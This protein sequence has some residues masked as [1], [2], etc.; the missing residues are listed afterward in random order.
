MARRLSESKKPYTVQVRG[1]TPIKKVREYLKA[2][3][4]YQSE[5]PLFEENPLDAVQFVTRKIDRDRWFKLS[6]FIFSVQTD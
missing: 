1:Y 3:G 5:S 4:I 6:R 2:L